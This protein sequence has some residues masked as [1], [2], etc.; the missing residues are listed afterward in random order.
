MPVPETI[1]VSRVCLRDEAYDRL[2]DW[3][4]D[5]T[6]AP[7]EPLRAEALGMSRTPVREALQRLEDDGL[8]VT[9]ANR[10]TQVSPVSL[11]QA[12]EV[13]PI[14]A[15]LE[16]LA[17]GLALTRM[18]DAALATMR[19]ANDDLAAALKA[20]DPAA[21]LTADT[22]IHGA[23]IEQSGNQE[24]INTLA[25]LKYK[26]RRIERAF[27]GSADRSASIADHAEL[28]AAL[29]QRDAPTARRV[30]IRNWE[31]GLRWINPDYPDQPDHTESLDQPNQLL[32]S[33]TAT[34]TG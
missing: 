10:R 14:V 9:T 15:T 7:G 29:E 6:L 3:I 30:L 22:T 32:A 19:R 4:L 27:W 18:D 17:I 23:F 31:R 2:R 11:K 28:I 1:A 33:T 26:V 12:R 8:A 24:L 16:E 21:A 25:E 13:Y 20:C 34:T 5:G